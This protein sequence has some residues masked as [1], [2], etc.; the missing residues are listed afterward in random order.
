MI[1][2][3]DE[4]SLQRDEETAFSLAAI[5]V[6]V[7][8][9]LAEGRASDR[10]S[11]T[12]PV[13]VSERN[14]G[15]AAETSTA[16]SGQRT[17]APWRCLTDALASAPDRL[18]EFVAMVRA[19]PRLS[20]AM[21]D[22]LIAEAVLCQ[23]VL[24][25][26]KRASIESLG[27]PVG[28][29]ALACAVASTPQISASN[30][31]TEF[32][33]ERTEV[34]DRLGTLVREECAGW[35]DLLLPS[36]EGHWSPC[37]QPPQEGPRPNAVIIDQFAKL[38]G[39]LARELHD[40]DALARLA[41]RK[42]PSSDEVRRHPGRK[43]LTRAFLLPDPASPRPLEVTPAERALRL[44]V[45][46]QFTRQFPVRAALKEARR[47]LQDPPALTQTALRL[48]WSELVGLV[49]YE[50]PDAEPWLPSL[51]GA[52]L[53][54]LLRASGTVKARA[55]RESLRAEFERRGREGQLTPTDWQELAELC[56]GEED[57]RDWARTTRGALQE[58]PP[59][60]AFPGDFTR[61][62]ELD[63][64]STRIVATWM[65]ADAEMMANAPA[66]LAAAR[67]PVERL[68]L[69]R[70]ALRQRR[71]AIMLEVANQLG[72]AMPADEAAVVYALAVLLA[73]AAS[74]EAD[75]ES[76]RST[77]ERYDRLASMLERRLAAARQAAPWLPEE[78][79]SAFREACTEL[80][81]RAL[82][83][84]DLRERRHRRYAPTGASTAPPEALAAGIGAT[85]RSLAYDGTRTQ[86][87]TAR[88]RH[89]LVG[90]VLWELDHRGPAAVEAVLRESE[91]PPPAWS[92]FWE[93]G[94]AR[95]EKP[96]LARAAFSHLGDRL[97]EAGWAMDAWTALLVQ[98]AERLTSPIPLTP[99]TS[100]LTVGTLQQML[101]KAGSAPPD[102]DAGE[103][104]ILKALQERV[105]L[106]LEPAL[107]L[108]RPPAEG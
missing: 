38:G 58:A 42:A 10:G 61:L 67:T 15:P 99:E 60:S 56:S 97:L 50:D 26:T 82:A 9:G 52:H 23:R 29:T 7:V 4:P 49:W 85:A 81:Q 93:A 28:L 59:V 89:S 17:K 95:L 100:A 46:Q 102:Q 13:L 80:H 74:H 40:R 35:E 2:P 47:K 83:C 103:E 12:A 57:L 106:A 108:L 101:A 105:A 21:A 22:W 75:L 72:A 34:R 68:W 79:A 91:Y 20:Q 73:D 44:G 70:G 36:A 90:G 51:A 8:E 78:V 45:A 92:A 37:A 19:E 64:P 11:E 96:A 1:E 33:K 69:A 77:A 3:A 30:W 84:G 6:P 27:R 24:D 88:V 55:M 14:A 86:E 66:L 53:L 18:P 104:N 31:A 48:L 16:H 71:P 5:I 25:R 32:R 87:E 41:Q 107:G 63:M 62:S 76:L 65:P 43:V 39:E 98:H 54:D 94:L